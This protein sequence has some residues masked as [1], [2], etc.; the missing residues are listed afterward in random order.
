MK[1]LKIDGA[2]KF[3]QFFKITVPLISPTTY[4]VLLMTTIVTFRVFS[5][6][7]LMTGPPVG[8]PLGTTK[9]IVYYIFETGL[10]E[11]MDLSY[12]STIALVLFFIILSV[13]LLQRKLEKKVHY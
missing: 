8:G 3:K 1:L 5:Q 6:V 7:Y 10:G 4:Y 12:A 11:A 9:V 13:T 2:S